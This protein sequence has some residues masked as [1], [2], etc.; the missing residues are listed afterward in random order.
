MSTS[1]AGHA[2]AAEHLPRRPISPV[3]TSY[4]AMYGARVIYAAWTDD[5]RM[6]RVRLYCCCGAATS[7]GSEW[8]PLTNA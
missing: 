8:W 6:Q 3:T 2:A 4:R 1:T 5:E 7:R